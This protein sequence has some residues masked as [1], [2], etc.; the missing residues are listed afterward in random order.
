L[1]DGTALGR[2]EEDITEVSRDFPNDI[3]ARAVAAE[4]RQAPTR[5]LRT[6]LYLIEVQHARVP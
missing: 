6:R 5:P 4:S 2:P 3:A 1:K